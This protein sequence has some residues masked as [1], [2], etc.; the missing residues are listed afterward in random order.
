MRIHRLAPLALLL[1]TPAAAAAATRLP[2]TVRIYD[3]TSD[4]A[5]RQR[6]LAVAAAALTP[7]GVEVRWVLPAGPDAGTL[8]P[9]DL[10]VRLARR[11]APDAAQRTMALGYAVVDASGRRGTV[12]TIFLERVDWLA[13]ISGA[14]PEEL[15]GLAIA[16]EV[17]HL[18]LGTNSHAPRGL[19][20]ARWTAEELRAQRPVDWQLLG[21]ERDQLRAGLAARL[22]T[23]PATATH[24][25]ALGG[26]TDADSRQ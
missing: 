4:H 3:M 25:A 19:M 23:R 17:G 2:L 24:V 11:G 12:A 21:R 22:G 10:V 16:H 14:D 8:E 7:A 9:Q 20:R 26:R 18:L 1:V 6:A 13:R 5:D 15:A